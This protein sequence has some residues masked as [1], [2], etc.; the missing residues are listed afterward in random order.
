MGGIYHKGLLGS[1]EENQCCFRDLE[2]GDEAEKVCLHLEED[3]VSRK[4]G[5]RY[6][7][8]MIMSFQEGF[9]AFLL[10]ESCVE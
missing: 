2:A 3:Q 9:L 6:F 7:K 10:A 5:N 8:H 1:T 4:K